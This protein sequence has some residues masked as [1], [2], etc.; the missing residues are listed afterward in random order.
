MESC[1]S[2]RKRYWSSP[3]PKSQVGCLG[4]MCPQPSIPGSGSQTGTDPCPATPCT[5]QVQEFEHIN[6]RWSMPELMPDPSAD[7]KRSSRASSPTKTSPTTP[8]A[9]AAN[10][11]CT[12]KP[13]NQLRMTGET[14]G[15]SFYQMQRA[16]NWGGEFLPSSLCLRRLL[17]FALCVPCR[18]FRCTQKVERGECVFFILLEVEVVRETRGLGGSQYVEGLH[19]RVLTL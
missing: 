3:H 13:G 8:E 4:P 2:S 1:L 19:T 10:S 16:W 14:D 11:P 5:L 7:S 12:S 9:S 18:S 15:A 17:A 6:G